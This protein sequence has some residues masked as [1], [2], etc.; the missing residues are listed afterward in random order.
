MQRE[1]V[2]VQLG[3]CC[4]HG[5][6]HLLAGLDLLAELLV[7]LQQLRPLLLQGLL[8]GVADQL[9]GGTLG[10]QLQTLVGDVQGGPDRGA[11]ALQLQHALAHSEDGVLHALHLLHE[12]RSDAL[13]RCLPPL[14]PVLQS[15]RVVAAGAAA[16]GQLSPQWVHDIGILAPL[17]LTPQRPNAVQVGER[18][19]L[20]SGMVPR[21]A[22]GAAERLEVAVSAIGAQP[23]GLCHACG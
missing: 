11:A 17:Q 16:A 18:V 23:A 22:K 5:N 3:L 2:L 6:A 10:S 12:G 13:L 1:L 7:G 4:V 14:E 15:T 19:R 20:P 9:L 21:R 8:E